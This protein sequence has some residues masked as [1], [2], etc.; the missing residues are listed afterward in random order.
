M[1]IISS[2]YALGQLRWAGLK[3]AYHELLTLVPGTVLSEISILFSNARNVSK[4]N[5]L[6]INDCTL[7]RLGLMRA[8]LT[9]DHERILLNISSIFYN[10]Q[11]TS[12]AS[13]R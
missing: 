6:I 10:A 5:N 11:V 2:S 1:I 4:E 9:L 8:C 12:N 13:K 7:C 3:I